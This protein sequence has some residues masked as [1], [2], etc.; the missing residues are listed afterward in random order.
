MKIASA[1]QSPQIFSLRFGQIVAQETQRSFSQRNF[2]QQRGLVRLREIFGLCQI[3]LGL[4]V[5]TQM[6]QRDPLRHFLPDSDL[7]FLELFG[8]GSCK[9]CQRLLVQALTSEGFS[10][11]DAK[12]GIPLAVRSQ[13]SG[14]DSVY[15]GPCASEIAAF[16]L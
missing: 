6:S 9:E 1:F 15:R 11:Q 16:K 4:G 3:F 12:P 2:A 14:R 13:T 10:L 7:G 8:K 5:A